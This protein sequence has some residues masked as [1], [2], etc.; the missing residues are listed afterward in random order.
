M[1]KANRYLAYTILLLMAW[2]CQSK[3]NTKLIVYTKAPIGAKIYIKLI[4]YFKEKEEIIDSATVINNH[5]SLI[6]NIPDQHEE[7]LFKV[8]TPGQYMQAVFIND[9]KLIRVHVN[10]FNHTNSVSGSRATNS[11]VDFENRQKLFSAQIHVITNRVDSLYKLHIKGPQIDSLQH[12]FDTKLSWYLNQYVNYCDTVKS[13]AAFAKIYNNVDF[14][15]DYKGLKKFIVY[16]AARFP[17]YPA[18]QEIKIRALRTV[19][20]Y[21]LEF[22]IGDKLPSIT[23]PDFNGKLFSTGSLKGQYYLIDFWSTWCPQCM[24]FKVAQ[25]K[26]LDGGLNNKVKFVSVAIDD[27][28]QIWQNLIQKNKLNWI[29]LIDEKMWDGPVV[30]T[31]VFD[32]IPFNFLVSPQGK[33]IKKAIKPDSLAKVIAELNK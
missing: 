3:N 33:V 26:I 24:T 21:E 5:D 1:V 6:M 18:I 15:T 17:D 25:K 22:M 7:R 11:L 28:K 31:L 8:V 19:R 14:D 4:P 12:Q 27:E 16:N 30:N 32:S 23:V 13:P 9:S 29:Q 10:Y 2:S 20:I